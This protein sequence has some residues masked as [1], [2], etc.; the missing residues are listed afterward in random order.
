MK[1]VAVGGGHGLARGLAALRLLDVEPTAV[2]TVADDGGSSGRLRRDLGII[3][4]GD[5]R[6]ALLALA[7]NERLAAAVEHRFYRGELEG[8]AL[9]N[10]LLVALAERAGGDFVAAL[11]E[12][13][14]L[15]DCA[16]RV[17]PS[18]E[19]PVKLRAR[20]GD[21]EIDGQVE[22]ARATGKIERVWLEPSDAAGCKE[23]VAAIAAADVAVLG[24]GS[25]FTSVVATL[26]GPDVGAVLR[27]GVARVVYVANVTTQPG[28]TTGLDA[29]A[30]VEALLEHVPG[31]RIDA[32]VLHDGPAGFGGGKPLGTALRHDA[33]GEVLRADVLARGPQGEPSYGHDPH[34][35]AEALGSLLGLGQPPAASRTPQHER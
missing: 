21:G 16:G 23:A 17:L 6:M 32:V 20:I 22:V 13:A 31:L 10:L 14:A 26:A 28:E 9:G 29:Q 11:D 7:R 5:L 18:T 27:D 3:A 8:H 19:V 33:V 15:L 4:P 1:V 34:R 35:L 25:L 2:V 12:A 30:H 24:P